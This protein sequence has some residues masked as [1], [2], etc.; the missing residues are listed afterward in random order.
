MIR[1]VFLK[2]RRFHLV[3]LEFDLTYLGYWGKRRDSLIKGSKMV[4]GTRRIR[5]YHGAMIYGLHKSLFIGCHHVAY[6]ESKI[7]FMI[8]I[9]DWLIK[10]GLEIK[11]CVIDREYY[12][13]NILKSFKIRGIPVITPVKNYKQLKKAKKE[14]IL[15]YK[16]RIQIFTVRTKNKKNRN[17]KLTRCWV[18][19]IPQ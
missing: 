6:R 18:H 13:Q 3:V 12:R 2:D 8:K 11:V 17:R 7:P 14:Y 1:F 4:K 9:A 15:G 19:L 16:G 10:L 5:H